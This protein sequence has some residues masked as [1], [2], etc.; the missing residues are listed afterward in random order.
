MDGLGLALF[1]IFLTSFAV[2]KPVSLYHQLTRSS[3]ESS[4]SNDS[5]SSEEVTVPR[6]TLQPVELKTMGPDSLGD[7]LHQTNDSTAHPR[8]AQ[9]TL[10]PSLTVQE[11][12]EIELNIS[13]V[14]LEP[15]VP[16]TGGPDAERLVAPNVTTPELRCYTVP[17]T[18]P[19]AKPVRGDNI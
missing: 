1:G 6:T 4:E 9:T 13:F 15:F 2:S 3:S 16:V 11:V 5:S 10:H 17:L 14:P 18:S 7:N 12:V 19:E 8:L